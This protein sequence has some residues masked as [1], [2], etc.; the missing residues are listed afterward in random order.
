MSD[1]ILPGI[2]EKGTVSV[3]ELI[4]E[5]KTHPDAW[6]I[7]AINVFIGMVRGETKTHQRV[8][9]LVIDSY[10][11]KASEAL[12]RI[13]H[14]LK[15]NEG[16][17]EVIMCHLVGE[18]EVGEDLVYVAVGAAHRE[19]LIPVIQE[20]IDLYK[21]EAE[22]WKKEFLENGSNYWVTEGKSKP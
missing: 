19:E 22:I 13:C 10:R 8:S 7:G 17:I 18:F 14:G 1:K 5:I 3:I 9:K 16:I 4:N 2:Y 15:K 12:R 20:A 21:S 6:K 11:E